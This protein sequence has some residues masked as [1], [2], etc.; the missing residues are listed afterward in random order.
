[1]QIIDP[2]KLL[3][4]YCNGYF[5]MADEHDGEIYWHAPDPR[6]IIPFE[7]IRMPRSLRQQLRKKPFEYKIDANFP[8]VIRECANRQDTWINEIIIN[9][10]KYL[11]K[12]NYA[13]SVEAYLDGKL[14]GGL[15]GVSVGG[16]FFGES[17]F[18]RESNASKAAFYH[19]VEHMKTKKF[20]LL[21]T[22]YIYHHTELLGAIEIP[23][24]EYL[25]MLSKAIRK[26][27]EF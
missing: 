24:H 17:M 4:A 1:M 27:V 11:H 7:T 12:Y 25:L 15:Y 23:K 19:L 18:S 10:F 8:E 5:P 9:S 26:Q 13:H 3:E 2:Q 22:Q 6:A 16:A 21:D 20:M 14:V